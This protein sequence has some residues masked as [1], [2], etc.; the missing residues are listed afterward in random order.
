[1][2]SIT[3]RVSQTMNESLARFAF[4]VPATASLLRRRQGHRKRP[5]ALTRAPSGR[6]LR[7]AG[8]PKRR[9]QYRKRRKMREGKRITRARSAPNK[10]Q[11]T[12]SWENDS[13]VE[14]TSGC[15][16]LSLIVPRSSATSICAFIHYACYLRRKITRQKRD[17]NAS[18]RNVSRSA[19]E[20]TID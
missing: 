2:S 13:A 19:R 5:G 16:G 1:M 17:N 20:M 8:Y 7:I 9:E 10:R 18:P 3:D 11:L 12:C 14:E 15:G 6:V 4:S